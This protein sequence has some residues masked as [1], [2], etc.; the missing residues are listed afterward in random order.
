MAARTLHRARSGS[1]GGPGLA[2]EVTQLLRDFRG[3]RR[4]AADELFPLVLEELRARAAD[5]L[6][7]ER[8]G[9]TLQTTALVHEAYLRLVRNE[10]HD[11]GGEADGGGGGGGGGAW[12]DRAHF[13]AVA[14]LAMRRILVDHARRRNR[15]R[16]EGG[17]A[18]GRVPLDSALL[19]MYESSA[20]VDVEALNAAL[21][22]LSQI[23]ARAAQVVDMRFFADMTVEEIACVLGVSVSTVEREWRYARAWLKDSLLHL[24]AGAE[25][26]VADEGQRAGAARR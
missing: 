11:R 24:P 20:G 16:R 15:A 18:G 19:I 6:R 13:F 23:R 10:D 4:L 14:A 26:D 9:H 3:G 7:C 17:A 12:A 8:R 2:E 22:E 1:E 21:T 5:L 25:E